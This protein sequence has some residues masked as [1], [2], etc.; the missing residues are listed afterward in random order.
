MIRRPP[1]STLF[2]YTTLFRSIDRKQHPLEVVAPDAGRD[3]EALRD[4]PCEELRRH[5]VVDHPRHEFPNELAWDRIFQPSKH[6]IPGLHDG[7]VIHQ[8][9]WRTDQDQTA[10]AVWIV[11]HHSLCDHAAGPI[12]TGA[13]SVDSNYPTYDA[14]PSAS[15]GEVGFDIESS[16]VY[17]PNATYDF[18]SEERR[19][20]NECTSRWSPYH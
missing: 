6:L 2:P 15:I 20:G 19:V 18:R 17:D 14:Y 13:F 1:R 16:K 3:L 9:R 7:L 5:R 10:N 8:R 4:R 12:G 11:K